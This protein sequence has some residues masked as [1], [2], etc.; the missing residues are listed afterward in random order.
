MRE[1]A[2]LDHQAE[3]PIDLQVIARFREQLQGR[4]DLGGVLGQMRVQIDTGIAGQQLAPPPG[5][6]RGWRVIREP[7]GDRVGEP[8][9]AVPALDEGGARRGA[10]P[11][12]E[13]LLG[14]LRSMSTLPAMRRM[15]RSQAARNSASVETGC[16]VVKTS[17]EVVPLATNRSRK[18]SARSAARSGEAK[19][20]SAGNAQAA[21]QSRSC[22][23]WLAT[24]STCGKVHVGVDEAGQH[25]AGAQILAAV[26][27][28]AP[29]GELR[30]RQG[31]FDAPVPHDQDAVL[32]VVHGA[33]G[34]PAGRRGEAQQRARGSGGASTRPPKPPGAARASAENAGTPFPWNAPSPSRVPVAVSLHSLAR[35]SFSVC[36][37]D[38][39]SHRNVRSA[40][41]LDPHRA[42]IRGM[43]GSPDTILP[44]DPTSRA[45]P[46]N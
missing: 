6:A 39:R 46:P 4:L 18:R 35:S 16:T 30:R 34:T 22:A 32:H 31:G 12:V 24:M 26:E 40:L 42:V 14:A 13:Q 44:A 28:A 38:G 41:R 1:H 11:G 5:A 36:D 2:A 7:R 33:A 20:A 25:E 23:P 29:S 10:V 19:A 43:A 15:R 45:S 17:A 21:S 27:A 3:V 37:R 9:G 8:A